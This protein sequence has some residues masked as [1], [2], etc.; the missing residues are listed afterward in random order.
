MPHHDQLTPA[1]TPP[2]RVERVRDTRSFEEDGD[3]WVPI[4]GSGD[5]RACDR[6]GRLHEIHADVVDAT[7]RAAVVGVGCM[8]ATVAEQRRLSGKATRDARR[9]AR[10]RAQAAAKTAFDAHAQA[11][12]A[13]VF[14][15]DQVQRQPADWGGKPAEEWRVQDA[16]PVIVSEWADHEER[17]R[18]LESNWRQR[19]MEERVGGADALRA[20]ERRAGTYYWP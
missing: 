20:L 2:F 3:R 14:P 8:N 16:G 17:I 10:A 5:P 19:R 13:M 9:A 1:L 15:R 7:G 6:C 12:A 18:C 11:V 4:P